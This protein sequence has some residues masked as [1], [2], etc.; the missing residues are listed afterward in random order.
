MKYIAHRGL[1][2]HHPENTLLAFEKAIH[3]GA[4]AIELDVQRCATG[5]LFVLHE[6]D[7]SRT[8]TGTG[9]VRQLSYEQ[10]KKLRVKDAHGNI[11]QH[12]MPTLNEVL[13][14][15]EG[16]LV[17]IEVKAA[18]SI[19]HLEGVVNEYIAAGRN[20]HDFLISSY[21]KTE[22]LRSL[23]VL[24]LVP[25]AVILW[26]TPSE[27]EIDLYASWG[28][29]AIHLDWNDGDTTEAVVRRIHDRGMCIGIYTINDESDA[30]AAE[31]LGVDYIFTDDI[32]R[33][34]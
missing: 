6:T 8:T 7:I 33:F 13:D 9:D 22:I 16:V 1:S 30:E 27:D 19:G 3:A 14:M 5:E 32:T 24:P 4:T 25:A 20:P 12:H 34:V 11:T 17:N 29:S 21:K 26:G 18:D 31:A 10:L 2:M 15:T 28:V 23:R